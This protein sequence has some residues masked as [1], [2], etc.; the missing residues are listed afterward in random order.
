MNLFQWQ[1]SL[2][3][4][5]AAIVRPMSDDM[6]ADKADYEHAL[7][8]LSRD[9]S[10]DAAFLEIGVLEDQPQPQPCPQSS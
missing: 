10:L 9:L 1:L 5:H 7:S 8:R 4:A 3:A 2:L 6:V